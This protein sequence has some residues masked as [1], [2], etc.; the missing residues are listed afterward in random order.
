MSDKSTNADLVMIGGGGHALSLLEIDGVNWKGYL[1]PS[2]SQEMPLPWLGDDSQALLLANEGVLFH[3]A[4]V[5]AGLPVMSKRAKL[6]EFYK[7]NGAEFASVI[8]P[9]A[10]ITPHSHIENGCAVMQRVLLNRCHIGENSI[11]NSGAIIEH[12]SSIGSNTFIGPGAVIGGFTSVGNNCFIGLGALLKNGIRI[13]DGVSVA[14]GA[15]IDRDL[16]EPG[17]Y[18]GS[19]LRLF[20]HKF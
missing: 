12:D 4:F 1:S 8:A 14:M 13:A 18:H 19:P 20:R 7:E 2:P 10:I 5:Y 11:I 16:L 17:I 9:S 3:M 6:I 15:K